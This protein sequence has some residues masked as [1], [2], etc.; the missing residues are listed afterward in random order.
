M[1]GPAAPRSRN[2]C[3]SRL[4]SVHIR[5]Q[6]LVP[7]RGMAGRSENCRMNGGFE[8][9]EIGGERHPD[10]ACAGNSLGNLS[11]AQPPERSP[12]ASTSGKGTAPRRSPTLRARWRRRRARPSR[13][14]TVV[15][16]HAGEP[17]TKLQASLSG[18]SEIV[19]QFEPISNFRRSPAQPGVRTCTLKSEAASAQSR[20]ATSRHRARAFGSRPE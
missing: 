12:R 8:V 4:A 16:V 2:A 3:R 7:R 20:A 10:G 17:E 19:R 6:R 11:G 14:E 5:R 15:R 1:K 18:G 13:W 9:L